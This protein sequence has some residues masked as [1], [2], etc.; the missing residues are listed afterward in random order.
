VSEILAV[1]IEDSEVVE[2]MGLFVSGFGPDSMSDLIVHIIYDDFCTYTARISKELGVEIKEY[3]IDGK[4]YLL[5]THPFTGE[6]II[7][8]PHKFLRV[9]PIATSY[10]DIASAAQH[11]EEL[12]RQFDQIVFPSLKEIMSDMSNKDEK[13]LESFKKDLSTLIDI[14]RKIEVD[15]Y[16]L[17]I[18]EKGYYAIDPFIE[19]ESRNIRTDKKPKNVQE[20]IEAVGEL[21]SQFRRSIEDNGGNDL[22]YRRTDTNKILKDNPHNED[23]AQRI[24]Y[25][26]ADLYCQQSN[27]LL[28]GESDA[29]RGPVDFSLG[30][31]YNEKVLVEIKKSNNKNLE[32]GYKDQ[33]EAY[34]KSENAAYSF[35]VVIVVKETKKIKDHVTQLETITNLFEANKKAGIKTPELVIIDGLIH[36]S[37]SKLRSVKKVT[38]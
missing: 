2:L 20:L 34:Q 25:M 17:K 7:F 30:T 33:I 16:N 26:I 5:P 8:V 15:S 6:Q 38:R 18:D 28:S 14:Y 19:H 3:K 13:E 27:I 29:G 4:K 31:G 10:D 22:L 36:P 12:R 11:N 37:P 32:S 24:F 35:Y 21:I 23:V 1:G 9:L